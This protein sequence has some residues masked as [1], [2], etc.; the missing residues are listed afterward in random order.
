VFQSFSG[1]RHKGSAPGPEYQGLENPYMTSAA[2]KMPYRMSWCRMRRGKGA[3]LLQHPVGAYNPEKGILSAGTITVKG[4]FCITYQ[5]QEGLHQ[6]DSSP[7]M[8]R[9]LLSKWPQ[10][11]HAG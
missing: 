4:S 8:G 9:T 10:K 5:Q 11:H 2:A 1:Q 6:T 3:R 7:L